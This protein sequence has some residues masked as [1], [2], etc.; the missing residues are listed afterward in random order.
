[1]LIISTTST[2]STVDLL[3]LRLR[4][5]VLNRWLALV[6]TGDGDSVAISLRLVDLVDL[7]DV[8]MLIEHCLLFLLLSNLGWL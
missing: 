2:D 5:E 6:A 8:N 3:I 4:E 7:V 1:M